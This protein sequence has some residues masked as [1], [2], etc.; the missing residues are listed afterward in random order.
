MSDKIG[1]QSSS[2]SWRFA[3]VHAGIGPQDQRRALEG[4]GGRAVDQRTRRMA[5]A[6]R[7]A[8]NTRAERLGLVARYRDV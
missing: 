1:T 5:C 8:L 2:G 4:E 6:H 3:L 7:L